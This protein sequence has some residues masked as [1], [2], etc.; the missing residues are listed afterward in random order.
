MTDVSEQ[1]D[2]IRKVRNTYIVPLLAR[3][4]LDTILG[5]K[6]EYQKRFPAS[7]VDVT[8]ELKPGL[9]YGLQAVVKILE[10]DLE[11]NA[12]ILIMAESIR[13]LNSK[14]GLT[15]NSKSGITWP[16]TGYRQ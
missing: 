14:S 15:S 12:R 10:S 5:I 11:V 13:H 8:V 6:Q 3:T 7:K 9:E 4:N 1:I 16:P 2:E